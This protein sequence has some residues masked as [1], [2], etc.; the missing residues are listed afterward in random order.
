V[1]HIAKRSNRHADILALENA[2]ALSAF[3]HVV[4]CP[5]TAL[6]VFEEMAVTQQAVEQGGDGGGAEQWT[7]LWVS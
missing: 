4:F 2:F 5:P 1:T 6:A 7:Y 3:R